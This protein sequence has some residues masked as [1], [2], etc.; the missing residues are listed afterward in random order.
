MLCSYF[1]ERVAKEVEEAYKNHK[2]AGSVGGC[3]ARQNIF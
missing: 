1:G 2:V 3:L